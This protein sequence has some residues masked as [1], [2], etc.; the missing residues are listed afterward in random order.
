M[1]FPRSYFEILG[2]DTSAA[3]EG[4]LMGFRVLAFLLLNCLIV[5]PGHADLYALVVGGLGGEPRFQDQFDANAQT[6][7]RAL[8]DDQ[9]DNVTLMFGQEAGREQ[10]LAAIGEIQARTKAAD[11]IAIFLIGHGSFDERQYKFNVPGPDITDADLSEMLEGFASNKVLLVNT[12]SAS[13]A[14]QKKLGSD[15]H[16]IITATKSGYEKNATHFGGYWVEALGSQEADLNKNETISAQEA[17]DYAVRKV[18]DYFEQEAR[19]ATEHAR[20]QGG[21][22]KGFSLARLGKP[23]VAITAQQ[24]ELF[25][26]KAQIEER[27][28]ALRLNKSQYTQQEYFERLQELALELALIQEQIDGAE[29]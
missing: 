16:I 27:I 15:D 9:T 8:E 21:T 1:V 6:L 2:V 3:V 20:M 5:P 4:N 10:F 14:L 22:P 7:A 26:Q 11:R 19:L 18:S 24:S 29:Q 23:V 12:S 28:E 25:R 13:G 17:F